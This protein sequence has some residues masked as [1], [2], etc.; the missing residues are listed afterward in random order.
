LIIYFVIIFEFEIAGGRRCLEKA[1]QRFFVSFA[2][3][4][5]RVEC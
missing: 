4:K 3:R 5:I 2:I 1:S